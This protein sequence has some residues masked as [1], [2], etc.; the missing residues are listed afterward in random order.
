[1]PPTRSQNR[2]RAARG[3]D[4]EAVTG[5]LERLGRARVTP[6]TRDHCEALFRQQVV[7]PNSHH[8]VAV[9]AEG[10]V[11]AFCSLHFRP[12][13]NQVREDAWIP[14]L[15]VREAS[16]REGI[17][18][19]MLAEAEQRAA[20]RGCR[21]LTLESGYERTN[22]H[23]LYRRFGMRDGGRYFV[24]DVEPAGDSEPPS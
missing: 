20:A 2:I 15:V 7:D 24:K 5:L 10:E 19:A 3:D 21:V 9:D 16:R 1:M 11:V 23:H 13:L 12:R 14:D 6:E 8:M 22:A 17:G 18:A 4:F